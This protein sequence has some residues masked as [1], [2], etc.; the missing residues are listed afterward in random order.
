MTRSRQR[1]LQRVQGKNAGKATWRLL[2]L[3]S[4]LIACVH[5]ARAADA[6]TDQ[7]TLDEVVVTAQKR[8]E[9][10]QDVPISIQAFGTQKLEELRITSFDDYAKY[11][12]SVSFQKDGGPSFEHTYI[13][14]ISSGGDGNHS[15]S[16]PS[17]GMYLDEQPITTIDGNLNLHLY[18]IERVEVLAGPQGTLY[19]ASSQSGTIRIIS[20]KPDLTKFS[21]GYDLD[22][23]QVDHGGTGYSVEAYVNLPLTSYAAVRLVGWD[24]YD[25]GY[26]DNVHGAVT[27]PTSGI[28][29]DNASQ[30]KNNYNTVETKGGRAALK[31]QINDNWTIMPTIMG[32]VAQTDGDFAY[33]PADGDLN[34]VH[35]FPDNT[36]D[37]WTQSALT[38][39]GK[40]WNLDVTYAGAYL[41][42]NTHE[43]SDYTDYSLFY[44][45]AYGSGASFKDNA[46]N[47]INPAQTIIGRDNY[48][49]YSNELRVATPTDYRF[50]FVGGLFQ[51]K[52]VHNILQD[53]VVD[54]GGDQLGSIPPNDISVPGWP[55]TIWLTDQ[56]RIDR[57][58]AIFGEAYFDIT[59]QLTAIAG[60]R[61]FTYSN[62]LQG[63]YGFNS[64]FSTHEGVATC[65]LPFTPFN[66]APC[67]D[68]YGV[69]SGTGNSPKASL[70]YKFDNDKMVYATFSKGFRPG[71]V[72]RNGG[73][74]LPPYQ[75]DYVK[76]YEIGWKTTW[77]DDRLRVNGALFVENWTSFQFSF[78]GP[79]ALT[80][81]ANAGDAQVRGF[82]TEIEFKAT[83]NLSLFGGLTLLDAK[84]TQTYCASADCQV[85]G[86]NFAAD[87]V[88]EYAPNG[89][90][91][92]VTPKYKGN[93]TARYTFPV[94]GF[95]GNVQASAITVGA[96][97]VD[98]RLQAQNAFGSEPSY[99]TLDLSTGLE[100]NHGMHLTLY[101]N[102]AF[103]RRATLDRYAECDILSCGAI[104]V[105]DV[106]NQPRTAGVKFGQSF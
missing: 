20:N 32:Q 77:L 2:P 82:E 89:T 75:P 36:H 14:G 59:P 98:L 85:P 48:T 80:I 34:V 91:L 97:N 5:S 92:P 22:V 46:G 104:A 1:K 86:Y 52:Q 17:V 102:N 103:D 94:F 15:G 40:L 26:I 71:G 55:G 18:D 63:Y 56:K 3:A 96:R 69:T 19:G 95:K 16:Q 58:K 23:N 29:F 28:V 62:S 44:D 47:L 60:L 76:N 9:N 99:T 84:L 105:Y 61:H 27:F 43:Q 30:V 35:W 6:S 10:L 41:L 83:N 37:S 90:R 49:K 88:E 8:S 21:A 70:Q 100:L 25:A 66:G 101:L 33:N 106:P 45:Q 12:P 68:L 54:N 93:L 67:Q 11:L 57:D 13:R 4:A 24:E 65:F 50:R 64:T 42:R 74:D 73:G 53:Y 78:L 87:P 31:V 79:N 72:N 38:V 81:I 39:Q 51:E 7:V